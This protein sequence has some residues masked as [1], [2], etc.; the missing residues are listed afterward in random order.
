M[1]LNFSLRGRLARLTSRFWRDAAQQ[2]SFATRQV[3]EAASLA[4]IVE[5][6]KP[7]PVPAANP[8]HLTLHTHIP[9]GLAP[10]APLIVLLHG[11]GQEPQSFATE[12]GWRL[13][14]DR[15][16][17]ALLMPGQTEANNRQTCFNW[18]RPGDVGRGLG[19]AG[20]IA[21]MTEAVIT[22]HR[23][24]RNQVFVTGLSAGA[25]MAACLLAAY[26]DVY[27]AGAIVAGLPAGAAT[28]VIN[29]MSRMSGRGGD[30][31]GQ[32]W[33]AIARGFAPTGFAGP[34]PRVSVWHG[35]ADT[36]V[37]PSN[38]EDVALQFASLHGLAQR[39]SRAV[40]GDGVRHS[41][42]TNG[43]HQLV[44]LWQLDAVGHI[45]PTDTNGGI[46]AAELILR[47]WQSRT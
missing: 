13:L 29:A 12:T 35:M 26:P 27:A 34:W 22:A 43:V 31:S 28:N 9:S 15:L 24:D 14:A 30:R 40:A 25:A 16:G 39:T 3:L 6:P 5:M 19:E 7:R 47:F 44:E 38:G 2:T 36:V 45:Y 1:A 37:A 42:W 4:P 46:P 11:C 18:F 17:L 10:G 8:G 33:A 41:V 23:C 32:D 21:A 20:S